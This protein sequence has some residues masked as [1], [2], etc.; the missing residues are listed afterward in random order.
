LVTQVDDL[1]RSFESFEH[2]GILDLMRRPNPYLLSILISIFSISGTPT[3][4]YAQDISSV[5]ETTSDFS[6]KYTAVTKKILQNAVEIERF[7]L[8][9]R[10][11]TLK[12]PKFRKL[13]YFLCQEAGAAGG[14]A[15]E[16]TALNEYG[17][18]RKRPL[19][20]DK[21]RF[22]NGLKATMTTSII[23]GSGSAFELANNTWLGLQ[24]REK[25]FDSKSA[26]KF[27]VDKLA[28][29]DELLAERER[30]VAANKDHPA[31]ERAVTEGQIFSDLR[32]S[33]INEFG[34]FYVDSRSA[35]TMQNTFYALNA[36]YNAIGATAAGVGYRALSRPKFTGTSNILFIV[37]GGLAGV[38]PLL[39]TASGMVMKKYSQHQINRDLPLRGKFDRAELSSK[40]KLLEAARSHD[41]GSLMPTL[42]ATE[43][44]GLYSDSQELFT[45]QLDNE[46]K[47][48]RRLDKV[49]LQTN[50]L[51]PP[52]GGLLMTQGI[53]GTYAYYEQ[54][55]QVR[56]QLSSNYKGAVAGTV[57]TSLSLVGNL[58]WL[59]T[60]MAYEHSL[61]KKNQLPSQ[62]IQERLHHLDD[63]EKILA[64]L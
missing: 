2:N 60:S 9:Y 3:P 38:T 40:L 32:N 4:V 43:R 47:V 34:H 57:G 52:I 17:K 13:R 61:K 58:G 54:K 46:L 64:G 22:G 35:Q 44:L 45:K 11:E 51:A 36:G 55:G 14:L 16:I 41:Q 23:A 30:L 1:V 50:L 42:S 63:V 20:F 25:G 27:V 28:S 37:S 7:S 21:D 8:N 12:Q 48:I 49:A 59:V 26:K 31:Y 5:S 18:G 53:L 33:F 29:I 10:L 6:T 24:R 62:L 19:T 56:K 15:F 39:S